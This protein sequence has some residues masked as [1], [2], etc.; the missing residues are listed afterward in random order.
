MRLCW[1]EDALN[2]GHRMPG[3]L[4][5]GVWWFWYPFAEGSL[6]SHLGPDDRGQ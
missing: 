5:I 6:V 1:H 4:A 3:S 2:G